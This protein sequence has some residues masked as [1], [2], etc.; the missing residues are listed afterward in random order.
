M[1]IHL[2]SSFLR[3]SEC[4]QKNGKYILGNKFWRQ[5]K[6]EEVKKEGGVREKEFNRV[7]NEMARKK[8][9]KNKFEK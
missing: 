3:S 5:R 1:Y 6:I 9:Y 4:R 2:L 8:E 7:H